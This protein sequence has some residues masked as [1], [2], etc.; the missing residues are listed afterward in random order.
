MH[1]VLV[2]LKVFTSVLNN[3]HFI[4]V[5]FTGLCTKNGLFLLSTLKYK[6]I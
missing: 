5:T 2:S 3:K 1:M 4:Q 6:I